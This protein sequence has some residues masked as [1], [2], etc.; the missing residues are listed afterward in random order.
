MYKESRSNN[1]LVVIIIIVL[2]H[3]N[4][5]K[6]IITFNVLLHLKIA[7]LFH[8]NILEIQRLIILTKP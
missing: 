1:L 7:L 8:P 5:F 6:C 3:L 2:L 4:V